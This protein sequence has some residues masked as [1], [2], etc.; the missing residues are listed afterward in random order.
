MAVNYLKQY[1][2]I[3]DGNDEEKSATAEDFNSAL[4]EL[5]DA[6]REFRTRLMHFPEKD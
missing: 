2:D 4:R 5:I 6:D 1:G 3:P